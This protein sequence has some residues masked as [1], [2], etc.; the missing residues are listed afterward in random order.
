MSASA[1]SARSFGTIPANNFS[2]A[3]SFSFHQLAYLTK[4]LLPSGKTLAL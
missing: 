2:S 4:V 3:Q 1:L